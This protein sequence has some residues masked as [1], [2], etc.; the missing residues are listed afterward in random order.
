MSEKSSDKSTQA[1]VRRQQIRALI[2]YILWVT[3]CFIGAQLVVV[4]IFAM[5][6]S[7]G[8]FAYGP[9]Q[10]IV[11]LT[12]KLL[13][14]VVM[15]V[16][17]VGL[18]KLIWREKTS[19]DVLGLGRL[20]QWKDIGFALIGVI[21][22]FIG[23]TLILWLSQYVLPWVDTEQ[24]QNLGVSLFNSGFEL[25]LAF[26]VFV[27]VGP[28]VE[29]VI[30]RGFLFGKLRKNGV[31]FWLTTVVVSTVF[32]IAHWQWNVALDVFFLSIVMCYLREKT[33]SIWASVFI[34]MI[35]NGVA[36]YFTFV[37]VLVSGL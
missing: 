10:N 9:S 13:A 27:V 33:G 30:F 25:A 32:A 14:F 29:E 31:P 7:V 35:K 18:P 21:V 4:I 17:L 23:S 22:A 6:N 36:F 3:I 34:H 11:S 28:F 5:L 24:T 15:V 16:A 8:A 12:A 1:A 19:L 26:V 37:Y 20:L 2:S